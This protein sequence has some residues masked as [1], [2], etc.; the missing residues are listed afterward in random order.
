[1][2]TTS[3][4]IAAA[5]VLGVLGVAVLPA[6]S[7]AADTIVEV[8]V[9][10][11]CVIGDAAGVGT[12]Q[13]PAAKLTLTLNAGA[14]FGETAATTG[15]GLMGVNCNDADGYTLTQSAATA[16]LNLATAPNVYGTTVGF[17]TWT[18]DT[19]TPAN[20]AANTW[21]MRYAGTEVL[22]AVAVYHSVPTAAGNI[23][24]ASAP[25]GYTTVSQQFA[26]KTDMSLA[27]GDY[28]TTITY[29]LTPKP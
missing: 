13:Q 16:T 15:S 9:G 12:N 18:T 8:T 29:T 4:L 10:G 17:T 26:A 25:T 7:F 24:N 3:K 11:V 28:G 14:P 21:S 2:K 27:P 19:T 6:A 5:S 20:F 22:P 23:I 1:M